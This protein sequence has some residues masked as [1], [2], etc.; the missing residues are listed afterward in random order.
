MNTRK[1]GL[2]VKRVAI[3]GVACTLIPTLSFAQGVM[4]IVDGRVGIGI[5]VPTA[6]LEV[7]GLAGT[8]GTGNSVLK[9]SRSGSLAFQFDSLDYDGFWNF[10]VAN[11]ESEF[12]IS[13]SGTSVV[14]MALTETGNLTITGQLVT[15]G[16][17]CSSG[18]DRVFDPDYELLSISDHADKMWTNKHLPAIGPTEPSKPVNIS[19]QF[20]NMLNE[21]ETAHIYI[22]QQHESI[23]QLSDEKETL[24]LKVND[25]ES[26]LTDLE[27][28]LSR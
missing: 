3:L 21:L 9:L 10:S 26:R 7:I 6:P 25:L 5:E 18:C 23:E 13:R 19:D 8:E 2:A 1:I 17:S 11:A 16:P 15:G 28:L 14:E 27:A 22:A 24:R 12:R 20:G 4:T